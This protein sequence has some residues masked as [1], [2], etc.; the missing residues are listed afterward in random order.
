MA[1]YSWSIPSGNTITGSTIIKD[2]DNKIQNTIDDLVDFVNG[3]GNHSESGLTY[4]LVTKNTT[5]VISG[6]KTFTG[7]LIGSLTG[8][9]SGSAT[10]ATTATALTTARDI[11]LSGVVTGTTSFNGSANVS[12]VTTAQAAITNYLI[13]AGAIIMWSGSVANIPYGWYLCNGGNGTP[14]LMDRMVIGAGSAYNVGAIGGSKDAIVVSHTHTAY[15]TDYGH[16]H[17]LNGEAIYGQA[18]DGT[19]SLQAGFGGGAALGWI[20]GINSATTGITV[21]N[22]T[23]GSGGTN[24][25]L[26]PYYALAFIMKG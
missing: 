22:S 23:T 12:I 7:G 15:V 16:T 5:Q 20:D 1:T 25:N 10:T 26:P 19:G 3:E 11:T 6:A 4:D 14:N 24:A 13:P 9:I 17:S 21:S 2:T 8:D 18:R